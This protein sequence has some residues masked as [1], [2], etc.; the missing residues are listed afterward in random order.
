MN[1]KIIMSEDADE[2]GIE[3]L[4]NIDDRNKLVGAMIFC[5]DDGYK[6]GFS[7]G[8]K[9]GFAECESPFK[10]RWFLQMAALVFCIL[11]FGG[12]IGG[13]MAYW[14]NHYLIDKTIEKVI[15]NP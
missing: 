15:D 7:K 4:N 12:M 14:S 9:K 3:A 5:Y 8:R 13:S 2:K 6:K 10:R 1:K 11:F